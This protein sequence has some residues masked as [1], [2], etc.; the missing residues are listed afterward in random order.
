MNLF[1]LLVIPDD[2]ASTLA[3]GPMAPRIRELAKEVRWFTDSRPKTDDELIER[4]GDAEAVLNVR[5]SVRFTR[6]AFQACHRLKVVSMWATGT[7]GADLQAASELG[8]TVCHTPGYATESVA[9]HAIAL[10]LA[11]TRELGANDRIV[12]EGG[13]VGRPIGQLYGRTLGVLGAG[14]IGRRIMELGRALGMNIA[15]W[16][17]H[18]SP[19]RA[20]AGGFTFMPLEAVLAV[21]DVLAIALA[22]GERTTALIDRD[23]LALMKPS[24]ILVNVGRGAVVDEAALIDALTTRR[25]AGAAL[26]VFARSPLAPGHPL[27]KLDNV[28]L[29]PHNAAQTPETNN[30]G[31]RMVVQN[32]EHFLGGRPMNV[33]TWGMRAAS[34]APRAVVDPL[35]E[36]E[37]SGEVTV[38]SRPLDRLEER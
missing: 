34:L 8:I 18:P 28:L 30:A 3:N 11:A 4:I 22:L 20:R 19:E 17:V 12:R 31:M 33:A 37:R 27:T 10:A 9:E 6:K 21:S 35:E 36:G 2:D 7:D 38:L 29:S 15:A 13:W 23:R 1:E 5:A 24:A 32:L 16:T 26:D 25:I 14:R